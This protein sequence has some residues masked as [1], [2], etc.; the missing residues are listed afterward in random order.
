M[1]I[2]DFGNY[3]KIEDESFFDIYQTFDCGQ[4]FRFENT[5]TNTVEGVALGRL[6]RL[7]QM[8]DGSIDINCTLDEFESIWKH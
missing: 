6:L 1:K 7:S 4:T 5:A 3:I 8:P 2:I